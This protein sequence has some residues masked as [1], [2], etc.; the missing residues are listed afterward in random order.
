MPGKGLKIIAS[1]RAVYSLAPNKLTFTVPADAQNG[2][3]LVALLCSK[4][5]EG[6][7]L[8]T[9]WTNM[10]GPGGATEAQLQVIARVHDEADPTSTVV[11]LLAVTGEW[12][13]ELLVV[14]GGSLAT[15]KEDTASAAFAADATPDLP[16][17][18]CHQAQNLVLCVVSAAN[19]IDFTAPAG[20]TAIDEFTTAIVTQRSLL[21]AWKQA[22]AAGVNLALPAAGANP[23]ATGRSFLYLVRERPLLTPAVLEDP[24][25]GNIGLLA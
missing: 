21:V 18:A 23:A 17:I 12:Q 25:S 4:P 1:S 6:F 8:P 24:V 19:A 16:A 10:V 20:F 11:S 5:G 13:G 7:T 9:G 3:L 15:L 22:K 14:R 2:D